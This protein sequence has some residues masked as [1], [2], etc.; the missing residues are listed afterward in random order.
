MR[1]VECISAGRIGDRA[2][3]SREAMQ[4]LQPRGMPTLARVRVGED[5]ERVPALQAEIGRSREGSEVRC[6]DERL[7]IAAAQDGTADGRADLERRVARLARPDVT[8]GDGERA[9][10]GREYRGGGRHLITAGKARALTREL[11][12]QP[13]ARCRDHTEHQP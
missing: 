10:I 5:P 11:A 9:K 3:Q 12:L 8:A 7:C 4:R 1:A 6:D 2:T 13:Y